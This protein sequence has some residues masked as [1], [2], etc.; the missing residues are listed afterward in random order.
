[1]DSNLE[2]PWTRELREALAGAVGAL[3]AGDPLG[4]EGRIADAVDAGWPASGEALTDLWDTARKVNDLTGSLKQFP[5]NAF[6]ER[7]INRAAAQAV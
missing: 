1:M 4:A 7:E 3:R 6:I 5:V 2:P